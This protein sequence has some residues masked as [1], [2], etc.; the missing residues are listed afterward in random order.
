MSKRSL[1]NHP[2]HVRTTGPKP[3]SPTATPSYEAL[4]H[5]SPHRPE[6]NAAEAL[7]D[8]VDWFVLQTDGWMRVVPV[9]DEHAVWLKWK[10]TSSR[11]PNH[12]VIVKCQSWQVPFGMMELVRKVKEV[13]AGE[14]APTL[15]RPYSLT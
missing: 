12:Y 6:D 5:P 13:L 2:D 8:A 9:P 10:F 14:R 11:W 1:S 3:Q 4:P 15:D 7:R